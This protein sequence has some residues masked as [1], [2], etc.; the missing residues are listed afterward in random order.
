MNTATLQRKLDQAISKDLTRGGYFTPEEA[1]QYYV[2]EV[3]D[4][5]NDIEVEVRVELSYD[6]MVEL[7]QLLDPIVQQVDPDA[8]F[9]VVEPGIMSAWISPGKVTA[10]SKIKANYGGAYDIDPDVFWT[11]DDLVELAYD[12]VDSLNAMLHNYEP[13]LDIGADID[14]YDVYIDNDNKTIVV[15]VQD[16]QSGYPYTTQFIPDMR[17]IRNPRDLARKYA[18]YC[19]KDIL[20]QIIKDNI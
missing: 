1:R 16:R 10:S 4:E 5:G 11:R 13:N 15:Q 20:N 3:H 19:A 12:V 17:K 2:V 9:D 8:Y 18:N 14:F 7:S 6:S